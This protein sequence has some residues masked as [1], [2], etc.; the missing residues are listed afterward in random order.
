MGLLVVNG[1]HKWASVHMAAGGIII[2][3]LRVLDV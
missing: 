3:G 2:N 1:W